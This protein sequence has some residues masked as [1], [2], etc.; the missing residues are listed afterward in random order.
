MGE[1]IVDGRLYR[2]DT[3]EGDA[4]LLENLDESRRIL[5]ASG[6]RLILLTIPPRAET[7]D[8]RVRDPAEDARFE[9]L[10]RLYRDFARAHADSVEVVE[11]SEILCPGGPPCPESIDGVRPRPR[12]GGHFEGQGPEWLAPRLLDAVVAALAQ[13]AVSA[14]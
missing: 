5:T 7:S 2:F 3:P 4:M 13:E 12:D 8:T 1:R 6:A 10:N 11:L 9:H 14:R